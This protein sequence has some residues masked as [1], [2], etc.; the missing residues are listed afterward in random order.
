M[1]CCSDVSG[2]IEGLSVCSLCSYRMAPE[3]PYPVPFDDCVRATVYF[4]HHATEMDVDP[5]RVAIAGT[6]DIIQILTVLRS[7]LKNFAPKLCNVA[8]G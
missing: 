5:A 7:T 1:N 2:Y 3:F 4:L 6:V 8:R